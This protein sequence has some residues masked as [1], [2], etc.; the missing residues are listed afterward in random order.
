MF[1][2]CKCGVLC[3]SMA[4]EIPASEVAMPT[5]T[6]SRDP[7]AWTKQRSSN[8]SATLYCI[9]GITVVGGDVPLMLNLL[10]HVYKTIV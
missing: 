3:G 6:P 5:T 1:Q 7:F 8:I 2:Q 4:T 9:Y 10:V